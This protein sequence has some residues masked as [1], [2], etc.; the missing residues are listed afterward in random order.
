MHRRAISSL[1]LCLALGTLALARNF[2]SGADAEVGKPSPTQPPSFAEAIRPLLQTKCWRCHDAK[3]HKAGL[4]LTTAAGILKG[5]ESGP[6][7]VPGKP[8]ES[9]L[10]EKVHGGVMPP[11]KKDRLSES[12]VATIRRWI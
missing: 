11:V 10:Y 3:T 1:L 6:A 12:E 8:D 2:L 4:D 7:L 5:G 9:L